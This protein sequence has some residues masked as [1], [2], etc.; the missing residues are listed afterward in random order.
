M[1][2]NDDFTIHTQVNFFIYL[3]D[4]IAQE[5]KLKI[6]TLHSCPFTLALE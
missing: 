1:T 5:N 6:T 3:E 4:D 2:C